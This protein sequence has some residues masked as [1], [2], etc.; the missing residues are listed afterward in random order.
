MMFGY[1]TDETPELMPMPFVL[2]TKL[3]EK[4]KKEKGFFRADAKAQVSFDY[5][6]WEINTFLCSVQHSQ[7]AE[8][9]QIFE[10]VS[11]LMKDVA[12]EF[13]LNTPFSFRSFSR[14]FVASTKGIGISSGVSSVA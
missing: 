9:G 11:Q 8:Q 14:S 10:R 3:L 12:S 5:D 6:K 2:A 7:K 4:L 13:A 1:A